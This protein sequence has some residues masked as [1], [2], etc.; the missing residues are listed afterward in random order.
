MKVRKKPIVVDAWPI[1]DLLNA[2]NIGAAGLPDKVRA[3][4]AEGLI[5]FETD[6]ITI[7]TLE[8]VMTGWPTWWLICGVKQEWY[9]CDQEA[10]EKSYDIDGDSGPSYADLHTE[11]VLLRQHVTAQ[12]SRPAIGL[13]PAPS[14]YVSNPETI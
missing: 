12:A 6:R 3:A 7:A 2:A 8:G 4:Y 13:P 5:E 10:F 1:D 14:A 9:P 11:V